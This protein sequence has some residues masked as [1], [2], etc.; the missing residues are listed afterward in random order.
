MKRLAYDVLLSLTED[1][2]RTFYPTGATKTA[3]G[4]WIPATENPDRSLDELLSDKEA[5]MEPPRL[6]HRDVTR[7]YTD[8]PHMALPHEPEAV[9]KVT[10]ELLSAEARERDRER[11]DATPLWVLLRELEEGGLSDR[12]KHAIRRRLDA[13]RRANNKQAA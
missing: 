3:R 7:G 11:A 8:D 9:D 5:R 1:E 6:L 2:L 4:H 13:A 10:Q 12:Y